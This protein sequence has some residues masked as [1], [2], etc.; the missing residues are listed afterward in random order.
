MSSSLLSPPKPVR[1]SVAQQALVR[2]EKIRVQG[3]FITVNALLLLLIAYTTYRSP[4]KYVRVN[5]EYATEDAHEIVCCDAKRGFGGEPCYAGMELSPVLSSTQ[6]AWVL[7][8]T[9]L[10]FNYICV[11]LGPQATMPRIRVRVRRAL[12]YLGVMA[13]RTVVL[14]VG[15]NE[16]ERRAVR[17]VFGGSGRDACWYAPLRRNQ[18]CSPH[19]DHSDHLVLLV[20]HY[21]AISVFEWFALRVE[22]PGRSAKKMALQAWIALVAGMAAYT[23]FFTASYF[24]TALENLVGLLI[25]Q[26]GVMLPLYLLSQDRF[27]KI[28][29]LQLKHFI[30]PPEDVKLH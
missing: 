13:V 28:P 21:L 1:F 20:S 10:I 24:H 30:N 14:Y 19:F 25:A 23:L 7:P 8:L 15:L 2:L 3:A 17:L 5:G 27:A 16:V 26:A 29:A 4:H 18:R 11:I 9:A 22:C 12:L 6:G